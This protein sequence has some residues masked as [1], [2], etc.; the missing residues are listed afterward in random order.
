MLTS[1]YRA[2]VMDNQDPEA[3]HRVRCQ[4]PSVL[5]TATTGWCWPVRPAV[6]APSINATVYVMFENGDPNNPVYFN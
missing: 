2:T 1:I 3:L 5:G 6:S 4:V